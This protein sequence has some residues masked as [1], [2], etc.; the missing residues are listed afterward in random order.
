MESNFAVRTVYYKLGRRIYWEQREQIQS[1]FV[2]LFKK[3]LFA[4]F[5]QF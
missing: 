4:T 1:L 3:K 5:L 2:F